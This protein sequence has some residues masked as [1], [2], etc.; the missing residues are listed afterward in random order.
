MHRKVRHG[1][2]NVDPLVLA[3]GKVLKVQLKPIAHRFLPNNTKP[4][5]QKHRVLR[6]GSYNV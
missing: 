6:N 1:K 5:V 2:G 4:V 3:I